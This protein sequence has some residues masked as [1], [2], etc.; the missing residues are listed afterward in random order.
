ME[1]IKWEHKAADLYERFVDLNGREPNKEEAGELMRQLWI[2][3]KRE[4]KFNLD[5]YEVEG[6]INET[7]KKYFNDKWK[8]Y[9][10]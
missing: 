2:Y 1:R 10:V 8:D 9:G 4:H 5:D 3:L 6:A 7:M